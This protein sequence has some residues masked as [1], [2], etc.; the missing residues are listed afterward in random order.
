M[1]KVL[2]QK[3]MG[4]DGMKGRVQRECATHLKP[5]IT[6][7][8]MSY[9]RPRK[10]LP[11]FHCQKRAHDED[12]LDY[13]HL[14]FRSAWREKSQELSGKLDSLRL[15]M[16]LKKSASVSWIRLENTWMRQIGGIFEIFRNG[17]RILDFYLLS[18]Q[19]MFLSTFRFRKLRSFMIEKDI[20]MV[21]SKSL[22]ES[23]LTYNIVS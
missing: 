9:L 21:V 19:I 8:V 12:L 10:S 4:S 7:I 2:L 22:I 6:Q 13:R 17:D 23:V 18:I 5:V 3:T 11:S 1:E 16:E 15:L 20:L 14:C